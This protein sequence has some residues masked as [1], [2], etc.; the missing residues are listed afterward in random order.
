MTGGAF[1]EGK[2]RS[3][4]NPITNPMYLSKVNAI[5]DLSK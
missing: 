5:D 1:L 2:D 4:I 3:S